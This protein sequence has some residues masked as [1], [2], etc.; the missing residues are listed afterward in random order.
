MAS[1]QHWK[2]NTTRLSYGELC[3]G[4]SVLD[5]YARSLITLEMWLRNNEERDRPGP[6]PEMKLVLPTFKRCN[7]DFRFLVSQSV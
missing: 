2:C 1:V 3:W 6:L 5:L 4:P 7:I